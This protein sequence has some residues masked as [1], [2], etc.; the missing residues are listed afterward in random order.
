MQ[1]LLIICVIIF[2]PL[3]SIVKKPY[4]DKTKGKGAYTFTAMLSLAA[5]LFFLVTGNGFAWNMSYIPYSVGFA[6]SYIVAGVFTVLAISEG[7]VSLTTLVLKYSLVLPTVYG[8]L[9]GEAVSF[10][11]LFGIALLLISMF[12]IN[13]PSKGEKCSFKWLVFSLLALFGN[14]MCTITQKMHQQVFAS[15]FKNEFMIVAL[16]I[17]FMASAFLAVFTE[18][19]SFKHYIKVGSIPA[20]LCGLM[21]GM[22]NLFVMILNNLIPASVMFPLISAGGIIVAYFASKILYKEKL[23]KWQFIGLI[24]GIISVVFLNL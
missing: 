24:I 5:L 15:E 19:K 20:V 4:T 3:Q 21:N 17:S 6:V 10:T 7:S 8:I 14:G 16:S 1:Y 18:R 2:I 22:V 9:L 13:K 11:L 23:Y 12:L